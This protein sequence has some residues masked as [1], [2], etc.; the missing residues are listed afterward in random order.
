[1]IFH[2]TRRLGQ[3]MASSYERA[4]ERWGQAPR[5]YGKATAPSMLQVVAPR[6][7]DPTPPRAA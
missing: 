1:M 6:D 2:G 7:D 4:K 3:R 5:V